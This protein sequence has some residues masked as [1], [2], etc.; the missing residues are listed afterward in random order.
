MKLGFFVR[1]EGKMTHRFSEVTDLT[2]TLL[3]VC[4]CGEA[5]RQIA[6]DANESFVTSDFERRNIQ[7]NPIRATSFVIVEKSFGTG[8]TL[9]YSF[10]NPPDAGWICSKTL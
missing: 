9:L 2:D 6:G 10:S 3:G 8:S 1:G 7:R 4:D 5:L